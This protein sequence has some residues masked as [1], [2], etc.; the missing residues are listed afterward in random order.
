MRVFVLG[1][2]QTCLFWQLIPYSLWEVPGLPPFLHLAV[3][4]FGFVTAGFALRKREARCCM[5]CAPD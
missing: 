4:L 3:A 2:F 5:T 1:V